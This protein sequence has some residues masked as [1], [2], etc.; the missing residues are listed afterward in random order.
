MSIIKRTTWYFASFLLGG[1]IGGAIALLYAPES[2]KHLRRDISR[3]TSDFIEDGKK[4]AHD[5]W[6][7]A[8]DKAENT[9]EIAKDYLNT[10]VDKIVRK[11]EKAKDALKC[12][13]DAYNNERKSGNENNSSLIEEDV[14]VANRINK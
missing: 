13:F 5:S 1:A 10:N 9:I 7:D 14:D 8:K 11:T 2:G 4:I 6:I 12:G 3:K